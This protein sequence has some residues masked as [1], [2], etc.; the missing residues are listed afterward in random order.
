MTLNITICIC[1]TFKTIPKQ[2]KIIKKYK[3]EVGSVEKYF[4]ELNIY[5]R[6]NSK[7]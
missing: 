2:K 7:G 3:I 1:K 5:H 4:I 6:L